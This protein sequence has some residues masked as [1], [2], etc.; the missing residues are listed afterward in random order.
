MNKTLPKEQFIIISSLGFLEYDKSEEEFIKLGY[1]PLNANTKL[2]WYKPK[3]N[4]PA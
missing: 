4:K 3:N 1:K 2:L